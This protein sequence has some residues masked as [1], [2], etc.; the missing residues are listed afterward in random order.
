MIQM[1]V[2]KFFERHPIK[3]MKIFD[4]NWGAICLNNGFVVSLFCN[5]N[6]DDGDGNLYDGC[7]EVC[8]DYFFHYDICGKPIWDKYYNYEWEGGFETEEDV[9]DTFD[10]LLKK[11]KNKQDYGKGE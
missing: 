11:Y 7:I 2:D 5:D 8:V 9:I 3:D 1:K 4:K 10:R 6:C